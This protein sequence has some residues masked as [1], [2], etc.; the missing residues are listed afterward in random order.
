M[1]ALRAPLRVVGADD[2]QVALGRC[3][4]PQSETAGTD[5]DRAEPVQVGG[6]AVDVAEQAHAD[7][8]LLA[9]RGREPRDPVEVAGPLQ[10]GD[11][12]DR[13][14]D[15]VLDERVDARRLA[16][17]EGVDEAAHGPLGDAGGGFG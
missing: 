16:L 2:L 8:V 9:Q 12:R 14:G 13:R 15:G 5:A 3:P 11:R 7:A 1:S 10:A 17:A 6:V 4:R